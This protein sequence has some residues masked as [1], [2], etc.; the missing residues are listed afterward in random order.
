[1]VSPTKC[2]VPS[3]SLGHA[4]A[5]AVAVYSPGPQQPSSV[6]EIRLSNMIDHMA[7]EKL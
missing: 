2:L 6:P 4:P 1:M 5:P 3:P 7:F